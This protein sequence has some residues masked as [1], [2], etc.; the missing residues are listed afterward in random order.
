[1]GY[2][3]IGEVAQTPVSNPDDFHGIY[4]IRSEANYINL[5]TF[6]TDIGTTDRSNYGQ[7]HPR[8]RDCI[9][10]SRLPT[11]FLVKQRGPRPTQQTT[12]SVKLLAILFGAP[13]CVQI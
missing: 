13:S 4:P 10:D 5:I 2:N 1:M 3:D 12:F 8:G 9:D 11:L 7:A 6:V